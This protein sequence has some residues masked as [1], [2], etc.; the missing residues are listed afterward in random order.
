MMQRSNKIG[1]TYKFNKSLAVFQVE[2]WIVFKT[3]TVFGAD[4]LT[5]GQEGG[6]WKEN[7]Q[8]RVSTNNEAAC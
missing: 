2:F 5:W 4:K 7:V 3:G 6:E 1:V 8:K